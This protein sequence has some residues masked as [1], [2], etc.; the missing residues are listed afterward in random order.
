MAK[1]VIGYFYT[2]AQSQTLVTTLLEQG[3]DP[4]LINIIHKEINTQE[5]DNDEEDFDPTLEQGGP[6]AEFKDALFEADLTEEDAIYYQSELE[7]GHALIAVYI[8]TN[9]EKGR[10]WENELSYD[11]SDTMRKVG[12]YDREIRPIYSNRGMTTYPQNR[13]MDPAGLINAKDRIYRSAS[14][15][16]QERSTTVGISTTQDVNTDNSG[17]REVVSGS[18]MVADFANS[19]LE[20]IQRA[21]EKNNQ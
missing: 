21:R 8:P 17:G 5:E 9:A 1:T 3:Y 2:H 11:I 16:N 20:L 10:L 6:V 7:K 18:S 14:P 13:F 12:A 19:E 4:S 15:L